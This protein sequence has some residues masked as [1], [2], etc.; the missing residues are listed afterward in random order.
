MLLF[1]DENEEEG[2]LKP[3]DV[4]EIQRTVT[5]SCTPSIACHLQTFSETCLGKAKF[6]AI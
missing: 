3:R 2:N 5:R 6:S 4:A 1:F